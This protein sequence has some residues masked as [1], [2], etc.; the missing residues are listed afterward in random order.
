[1]RLPLP[2]TPGK[3]GV[4]VTGAAIGSGPDHAPPARL[5]A[6]EMRPPAALSHHTAPASP[7]RPRAIAGLPPAVTFVSEIGDG[8]LPAGGTGARDGDQRAEDDGGGEE[9]PW[10]RGVESCADA[11][12]RAAAIQR[13]AGGLGGR[14]LTSSRIRRTPC[15]GQGARSTAGRARLSAAR[16]RTRPGGNVNAVTRI[17]AVTAT[18]AVLAV[19]SPAAGADTTWTK[20]STDYD[21]NIVDPLARADRARPQSSRGRSRRARR[22]AIST[23]SASR[24]RRR[25]T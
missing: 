9:R 6:R 16:G 10:R 5:R 11:S 14:A 24:P 12:G 7:E 4:A 18:L 23:R 20:I 25:R 1:M 21:A 3:N 2:S 22:R 15:P 17:A 13:S 19:G 8:P